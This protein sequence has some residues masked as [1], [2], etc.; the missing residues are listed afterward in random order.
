[1]NIKYIID[2]N[3][4]GFTFE[5]SLIIFTLNLFVTC[6]KSNSLFKLLEVE[7]VFYYPVFYSTYTVE[8][9]KR[10]YKNRIVVN[11]I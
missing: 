10:E 6:L 2:L 1:M 7:T 9:K 8:N 11:T 3:R 5:I 4:M